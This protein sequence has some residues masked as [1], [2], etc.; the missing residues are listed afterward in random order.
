MSNPSPELVDAALRG[1]D[2]DLDDLARAWLPHVYAWCHRLG[3]PTVDAEDAAH[4]VLI[5]MCRRIHKVNSP[6][7]F[8]SWL[9][10]ITRRVIANHR[11]KAWV[12]RW[13]PGASREREDT[14]WSP[15]RTAEAR[16]TAESVWQALDA[17]PESQREVLVLIELEERNGTEVAELLDLPLGTVKSRLRAAR[18]RFRQVIERDCAGLLPAPTSSVEVG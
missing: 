10:G 11:R 16:Q 4:E 2:G 15:L 6:G 1:D 14:S 8:P 18:R 5:I 17:L 7:Q 3:G 12:R 9:F 13:V